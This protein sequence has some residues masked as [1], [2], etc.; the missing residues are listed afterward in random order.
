MAQNPTTRSR[1]QRLMEDGEGPGQD[2]SEYKGRL[3]GAINQALTE[4]ADVKAQISSA[5]LTSAQK[6][7]ATS[8]LD[9]AVSLLGNA[10]DKLSGGDLQGAWVSFNQAKLIVGQAQRFVE[11]DLEG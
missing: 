5:P 4:V 6:A 3:G 10:S 1:R 2:Q 11:G 7:N 8:M 9:S